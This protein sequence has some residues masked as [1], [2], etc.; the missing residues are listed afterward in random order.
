M[1]FMLCLYVDISFHTY[2]YIYIYIYIHIHIYIYIHVY[3]YIHIYIYIYIYIYLHIFSNHIWAY[4]TKEKRFAMFFLLSG[5]I[6]LFCRRFGSEVS[7]LWDCLPKIFERVLKQ[8]SDLG[9]A[10]MAGMAGR[11]PAC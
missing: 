9:M 6:P 3:I 7:S 4:S 11:W 2:T 1:D 8:K 10:G 5:M